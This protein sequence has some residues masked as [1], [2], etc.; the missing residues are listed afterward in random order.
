MRSHA[1]LLIF[2]ALLALTLGLAA[3][4]GGAVPPTPLPETPTPVPPTPT[5]TPE[6]R[7]LTICIGAEP[8]SLYLNNGTSHA[9]WSI[10][11]SIYDGPIDTLG[12]VNTPVILDSLPDAANGGLV[13]QPVA[14]QRGQYILDAD[15]N[16]V[17]L[18]TGV[19][20]RPAGCADASCAVAWDGI[21][22][23][24]MTQVSLKYTLLAG[25]LWSDG[26]PLTAA[27]SVYAYGVAAD[28]A[29]PVS[30]YRVDR[31]ASYQASDD[32]TVVW[33]GIPGFV[34][35]DPSEFFWLPLPQHAWSEYSAA[36]LLTVDAANRT[37]LGWG[38]YVIQEWVAGD[39]ISLQRNPNYFR[40][41]EGL[42]KFDLLTYRF[43]GEPADNNL[44]AL[45]NGECDI[46]DQSVDW[47]G[48]L[49]N[50]TDLQDKGSLKFYTTTGPEWEHI[51]LGIQL[52]A[53][54]GGYSPY[55]DYRAAIFN[56]V[57]VRQAFTYCTDRQGIVDKL[58]YGYSQVPAGFYPA[59]HPL[60]AADLTALPYDPAEGARLLNEAGWVDLDGDPATPRVSQGITYI[61]NDVPLTVNYTAADSR[62]HQQTADLLVESMAA[63][64]I[65]V[66]VQLTDAAT[67]Y[68]PGPQGALFGRNFDLAEY[69][70]Q[71]GD[72]SPCFLYSSNQIP[73]AD[74]NWL[75]VNVSGFADD[76]YDA[77]CATAL[78][79]D[80]SQS[81]A[82]QSANAGVQQLYNE[83][84]PSIPLYFSLKL[85]AAQP[86]VCNFGLDASARSEF[87]NLEALDISAN[88]AQ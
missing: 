5:A 87:W 56:D 44:A 23:L 75:G 73:N 40:A 9:K 49:M 41:S 13:S 79:A 16:P 21:T 17:Y 83:Q 14:V 42:P 18:D 43:L 48:Q 64:G 66:N 6:P 70:W 12:Y 35:S 28:P 36:D 22:P 67:L 57:R 74:N 77:A 33:T 20:L 2:A 25:L 45:T 32:Q 61:L 69:A 59:D 76:T 86:Q 37:P 19:S 47:D 29:T 78:A 58:L 50:L 85:A 26:Q 81:E 8:Q 88:C 53:Y 52:A 39:H 7:E 65:Q 30:T 82:Y 55:S 60:F 15:G 1:F 68:A 62:L 72:T 10:L 31:T 46:V 63:C 38:P 80:P 24:E 3:C 4:G 71:S 11:E 51:D 34:P 27:D 84:I 54:D